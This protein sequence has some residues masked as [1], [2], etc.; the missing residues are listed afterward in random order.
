MTLDE[1]VQHGNAAQEAVDRIIADHHARVQQP[2]D[3]PW[4]PAL[5]RK[6]VTAGMT[7]WALFCRYEWRPATVCKIGPARVEIIWSSG[8]CRHAHRPVEQ[9]RGRDPEKHDKPAHPFIL[10]EMHDDRVAPAVAVQRSRPRRVRAK[11]WR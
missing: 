1:F 10:R 7:V 2:A 5:N 9:L 8:S 6:A 4:G 3:Y 11:A